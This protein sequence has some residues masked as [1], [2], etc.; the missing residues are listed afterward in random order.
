MKFVSI[1]YLW[2]VEHATSFSFWFLLTQ[3]SKVSMCQFSSPVQSAIHWTYDRLNQ[4]SPRP[5]GP[6]WIFSPADWTRPF[7]TLAGNQPFPS[8]VLRLVL[9]R[10]QQTP[11][12]ATA[13]HG[14]QGRSIDDINDI[15]SDKTSDSDGQRGNDNINRCSDRTGAVVEFKKKRTSCRKF[16]TYLHFR[17]QGP[18][19]LHHLVRIHNK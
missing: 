9:R 11:A 8:W 1:A 10:R 5:F 18:G 15:A 4:S 2:K 12:E 6:D 19:H 3:I 13:G 16:G 14:R 17:K 7:H